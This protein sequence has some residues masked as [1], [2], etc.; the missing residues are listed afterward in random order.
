MWSKSHTKAAI[1]K[2]AGDQLIKLVTLGLTEQEA[3]EQVING[4]LS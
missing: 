4:F 1:G 3:E 2:V